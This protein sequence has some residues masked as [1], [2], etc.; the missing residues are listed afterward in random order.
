MSKS[1]PKTAPRKAEPLSVKFP[2]AAG[3]DLGAYEHYVAINPEQSDQPIRT[4]GVTTPDLRA[5]A[6]FLREHG[7]TTVA[8]EATGVYWMPVFDVL[9]AAGF[10]VVLVDPKQLKNYGHKKTDVFDCEAIRQRHALG[11]LAGAFVPEEAIRSLRSLTRLRQRLVE[12]AARSIQHMHKSLERMN[13]QLHKVLSDVTGVSGMQ[14]IRAI[15][16]GERGPAH[17]YQYV[18]KGVKTPKDEFLKALVG[19]YRADGLLE[20]RMAVEN[21]DHLHTQIEEVDTALRDAMRQ[22]SPAKPSDPEAPIPG[23]KSPK[24]GTQSRRKNEPYFDLKSEQ[25]RLMGVDLTAIEGVGVQTV[26][27]LLSELGTN[28]SP[29]PTVGQFVSWLGLCP[30]LQITGGKIKRSK[31]RKVKNRVATA[32]R[33][34]AQSLHKSDSALGAFYRRTAARRGSAKAITATARK[35]AERCYWMMTKG[36]DYV[37][38]GAEEYERRYK[39]RQLAFVKKFAAE[40]GLQLIVPETS[41]PAAH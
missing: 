39:E 17:L 16:R 7:V 15:L 5:L 38:Q 22:C 12:D 29:F 32:L 1:T 21:Y 37:R 36:M 19:V 40:H 27:V 6:E 41:A 3:I 31:S 4:F 35:L 30:N 10:E 18:N 23:A 34:A 9:E 25:I 28:W 11:L 20:L 13:L 14:I 2:N 26:Q 8:M 33:I 24:K